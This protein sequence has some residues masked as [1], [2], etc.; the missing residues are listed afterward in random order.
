MFSLN[1]CFAKGFGCTTPLPVTEMKKVFALIVIFT[2]CH[3]AFSQSVV[4]AMKRK[5]GLKKDKELILE[6]QELF[7]AINDSLGIDLSVADTLYYIRG[8]DVQDRI[9]YGIV[10]NDDIAISYSDSRIW[11]NNR[12]VG[13]NP[14][15]IIEPDVGSIQDFG[16]IISAIEEGD[17]GNVLKYVEESSKV[18][19]GIGYWNIVTFIKKSGR[20][21]VEHFRVRDFA[22]LK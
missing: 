4:E 15:F 16:P 22:R 5:K 13:S 19:S 11:E 8:V 14:R 1:P 12:I 21:T 18:F 2:L 7:K 3:T 20:Y 10:W 6:A 9:G 17:K